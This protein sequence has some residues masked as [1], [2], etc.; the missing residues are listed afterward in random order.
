MKT[1]FPYAAAAA[2]RWG[3][4]GCRSSKKTGGLSASGEKTDRFRNSS[5][6]PAGS[7]KMSAAHHAHSHRHAHGTHH[8]AAENVL[9]Q[10]EFLSFGCRDYIPLRF[11]CQ[12][13]SF[14]LWMLTKFR[15]GYFKF[16]VHLSI[17]VCARQH[18]PSN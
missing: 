15:R 7:R 16:L 8:F 3:Q 4:P 17:P 9:H 11:F 2:A 13:E 18:Q 10:R 12:R 1:V 5:Q 14:F 6:N